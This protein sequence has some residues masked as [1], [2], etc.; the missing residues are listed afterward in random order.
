LQNFLVML[1]PPPL[2]TPC[3]CVLSAGKV[4]RYSFVHSFGRLAREQGVLGLW[5]GNTPYLM[6]HVPS[7]SMSF[8]FKVRT[9]LVLSVG[10]NGL[11]T[12]MQRRHQRQQEWQQQQEGQLH[13]VVLAVPATAA[14]HYNSGH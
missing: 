12:S 14:M 13:H 11:K 6:R 8:A 10:P 1:L 7:I 4:P 3:H 9:V 2:I 5:R